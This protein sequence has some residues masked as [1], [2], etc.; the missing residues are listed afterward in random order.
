MPERTAL[1]DL[2][3]I[4]DWRDACRAKHGSYC[5]DRYSELLSNHLDSLTLVDVH[6]NAL[7]TLPVSTPYVALSYVWGN[8]KVVKAQS[9]N[10]EE[11]KRPGALARDDIALPDTIRDAIHLV[12]ELGEQYLWVDALSVT[13]D[14]DKG[15]MDSM[16]RAMAH[17]YASAEFTIV[18]AYGPDA[19]YSLR[20]T[21]GPSNPRDLIDPPLPGED[22]SHYPQGS[23]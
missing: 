21:S 9:L 3:Q 23:L 2:D 14:Q 13:Q 11:L 12:K 15:T 5:N 17:I 6:T 7:V 22:N 19:N 10:S 20:G 16:L 1:I 8:A 18:A 4:R